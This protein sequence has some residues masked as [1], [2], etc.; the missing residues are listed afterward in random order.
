MADEVPLGRRERK[1]ALTR[2]TIRDAALELFLERGFDAVTVRE[3][4][5]KADVTPKTVFSHFP[6]KEALL[7]FD[8]DERHALLA[9]AVR[10]R[11]PG[12]TISE[13]LKA[14]YLAEIAAMASEPYRRVLALMEEAPSLIDYAEKMWL[15]HQDSLVEVI[16]AEFGQT[17]PSDEI[18]FYVRFALQ[19]QLVASHDTDPAAT[20]DNG[21]RLLD[22]GWGRYSDLSR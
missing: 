12:T 18:R 5:E 4:A 20:I 19:I 16:T 13:A 1:K 9:A 8:E 21:F 11:P 3:I 17:E 7:F 10:D 14:H 15:R 6:H 22:E 2:A